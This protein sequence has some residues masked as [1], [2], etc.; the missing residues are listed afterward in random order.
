MRRFKN[1]LMVFNTNKKLL[2]RST[3]L[4]KNN[5]ARLTVVDIIE[6]LHRDASVDSDD[7]PPVEFQELVIKERQMRLEQFIEP[8]RKEGVRVTAK[9]LIGTPFLEIIREVLREKHDLV[10]IA[11]EGR[12]GY[13]ERLFGTTSMHLMR[14]CPCPV[15]VIKQS[16]RKRYSSILA[17]VDPD[18]A[19]HTRNE[20]NTRIMD[21]A[22]SLAHQE[23]SQLNV[24]HVWSLVLENSL[25]LR[26]TLFENEVSKMLSETRERHN[27]RLE[28]LVS[29]YDLKGLDCETHLLKGSARDVIP[30]L[31]E[32]KEVDLIVMGSVTRTGISGFLIG[33]T[34]EEI[35]NKVDCSVLVVKPDDFVTP[36][37]LPG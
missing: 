33:N 20:L 17:A 9:V 2:E 24:V 4:A 31:A 19:D 11:A 21:L 22:T 7:M 12:G 1:I 16:R 8:I 26:S 30:L 10:T 15:W 36:V 29:R 6:E 25:R 14:K 13:K 23:K 18:P 5:A 3:N 28:D 37:K 34:A 32:K 35:L 27:N